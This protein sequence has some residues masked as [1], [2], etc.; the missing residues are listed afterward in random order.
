MQTRNSFQILINHL[1]PQS[2]HTTP[3]GRLTKRSGLNPNSLQAR[4]RG[5]RRLVTPCSALT[6]PLMLHAHDG[7]WSSSPP[8]CGIVRPSV[9]N[10]VFRLG[11]LTAFRLIVPRP[12][13]TGMSGIFNTPPPVIGRR[14]IVAPLSIC[15][16][17]KPGVQKK[18]KE[19]PLHPPW[20]PLRF[21]SSLSCAPYSTGG[22]PR[23]AWEYGDGCRGGEGAV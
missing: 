7:T 5:E 10:R 4:E 3:S 13:G 19:K 21:P 11:R 15:G 23:R 9:A 1:R 6:N 12:C 14:R 22:V 16:K 8:R 20:P 2:Q 17:R 18:R